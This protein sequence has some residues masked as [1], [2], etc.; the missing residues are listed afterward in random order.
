MVATGGVPLDAMGQ[1]LI[2]L[3]PNLAAMSDGLKN[4]TVTQDEFM[5]EIRKTAEMADNMSD[6]KKQQY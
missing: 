2:R 3:N 6:A 1:D 5:A 4:G